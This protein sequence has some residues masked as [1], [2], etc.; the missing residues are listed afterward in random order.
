MAPGLG[1]E[2]DLSYVFPFEFGGVHQHHGGVGAAGGSDHVAR[3]LLVA[4][5]VANDELARRGGKVAVGHV[6]GD[7]LFA[8]SGQAVGKQR[9]IGRAALGHV[10]QLVLQHRA[11]VHQQAANQRAFA[12]VNRAAGNEFQGCV[13]VQLA[14]GRACLGGVGGDSGH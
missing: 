14:A 8:L 6:N 12:V 7:A 11:A 5:R 3:V 2:F 1:Q 10:V 13:A 4:G 9:Q